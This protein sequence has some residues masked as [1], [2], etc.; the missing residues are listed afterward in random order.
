MLWYYELQ[1][2]ENVEKVY[3]ESITTAENPDELTA[4]LAEIYLYS[5][6]LYNSAKLT[7]SLPSGKAQTDLKEKIN[8]EIIYAES[9]VQ[10]KIIEDFPEL[11]DEEISE[12]LQRKLRVDENDFIESN[13][14]MVADR[15]RA[16]SLGNKI[17]YGIRDKNLNTH[18][19]GLT[20]YK[21][22][23]LQ[24]NENFPDNTDQNLYGIEY[25]FKRKERNQKLNYSASTRIEFNEAS[26]AFYHA[27]A[28][29][30]FAKDSLFSSAQLLFRP[31][32]TGPAYSLGIY[33]TQL[34]IYEE[35]QLNKHWRGI[36]SL[37]SNYYSD[38]VLDGLLLTNLGYKIKIRE[39]SS[40]LPYTEI[41]GMLGNTNRENGYPYWTIN[42]R[43]YG[44]LG[45]EYAYIDP[46]SELKFSLGAATF[47]YV[48]R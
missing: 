26:K 13:S 47:R 1:D 20:Q 37:E 12:K 31:A 3:N 28:N 44:G 6:K 17:A 35:L 27:Q 16:T 8:K 11:I 10:Q 42:E 45:I 43:L 48:F 46:K 4:T 25:S 41:S 29:I 18:T 39:K 32:I 33:Q 24:L 14:N 7:A 9:D 15:L 23:S 36:L 2:L 40:L 30:S 21:A 22:F 38:D 5:N 34:T 19:F